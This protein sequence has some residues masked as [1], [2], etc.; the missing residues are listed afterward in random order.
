MTGG[1][2]KAQQRG[3]LPRKQVIGTRRKP[4]DQLGM[5][6]PTQQLNQLVDPL[7]HDDILPPQPVRPQ[8][9][10]KS[11]NPFAKKPR[12]DTPQTAYRKGDLFYGLARPR[13]NVMRDVVGDID[14]HLH[15]YKGEDTTGGG[16]RALI[17]DTLNNQFLGTGDWRNNP[18]IDH[19]K[20][21][22][23]QRRQLDSYQGKTSHESKEV[24]D[25]RKFMEGH[26]R[27]DPRKISGP[28]HVQDRIGKACKGGIEY[29]TKHK[30]NHLHM[31]LDDFNP[32]YLMDDLTLTKD[33]RGVTGKE[34]KYLY[35]NRDEKHIKKRVNFWK[36]G[37]RA[38]APWESDPETW[39][40]YEQYRQEKHKNQK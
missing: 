38:P 1:W 10:K 4:L 33:M 26:D 8:P 6:Q 28:E 12:G 2:V 13:E 9:Q 25:Y 39:Q 5:Q 14:P 7:P 29:T 15:A 36:D 40:K 22:V 34:M 21:P 24:R 16:K 23:E 32:K 30:K 18:N 17:A 31:V 20:V 37:E 11:W 19:K 3:D 27:Y 35:R